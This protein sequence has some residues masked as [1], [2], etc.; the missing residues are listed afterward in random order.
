MERN[1]LRY[2]SVKEYAD[3]KSITVQAVYKQ[4]KEGKVRTKEFLGRILICLWRLNILNYGK[5]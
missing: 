2:M 3:S 5:R 4:I 1:K